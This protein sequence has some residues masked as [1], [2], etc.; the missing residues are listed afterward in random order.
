MK[1]KWV[2]TEY[3]EEFSGVRGK[4]ED[5]GEMTFS[6][7]AYGYLSLVWNVSEGPCSE[8]GKC[9]RQTLKSLPSPK[10]SPVNSLNERRGGYAV[11]LRWWGMETMN[12]RRKQQFHQSIELFVKNFRAWAGV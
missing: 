2:K 4:I 9:T 10:D 6:G 12:E 11:Y 5:D 8:T 7:C 3:R 1:R